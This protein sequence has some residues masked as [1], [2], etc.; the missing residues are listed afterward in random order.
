MSHSC[1]ALFIYKQ[2]DHHEVAL[3]E[4]AG[5]YSCIKK[6]EILTFEG[7]DAGRLCCRRGLA[8]ASFGCSSSLGFCEGS[9]VPICLAPCSLT[10]EMSS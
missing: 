8:G 10:M 2:W 9:V 5:L 3:A 1:S 4:C 6:K 7:L